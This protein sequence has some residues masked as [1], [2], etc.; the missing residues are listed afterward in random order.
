MTEKKCE[1]LSNVILNYLKRNPDA[2]DTLE[3][4]ALWWVEQE[5]ID[6]TVEEVAKALKMLVRKGLISVYKTKS[7][8]RI[9]KI[10]NPKNI[11]S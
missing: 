3:G 1:N 8:D 4:I 11:S 9:Y 6:N 5:K 2:G 7:S 10:K